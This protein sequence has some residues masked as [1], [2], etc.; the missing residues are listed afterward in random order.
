M[1]ACAI[2]WQTVGIRRCHDDSDCPVRAS[3]WCSQC[4]CY[5]HRPA[6][7]DDVTHVTRPVTL[8]ELIPTD[9]R[10]RWGIDTTTTLQLPTVPSLEDCER[11]IAEINT[12][13]VRYR[14]G[15]RDAKIREIMRS[16][17]IP[18]VHKMDDNLQRLRRWAVANG[19]KV[20]LVQE[21]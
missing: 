15:S 6:E 16:L 18:T 21:R 1:S 5:G 8:E 7:C 9:V 2:C 10:E 11:E 20:C 13:E 12:I 19:K 3:F 17:K 14:E 4:G